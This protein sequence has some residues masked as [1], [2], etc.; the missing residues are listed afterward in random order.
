[1]KRIACILLV[2]L[3]IVPLNIAAE[4]KVGDGTW[5]AYVSGT[6]TIVNGQVTS[7]SLDPNSPITITG[8]GGV[9]PPG[10]VVP[11][12]VPGATL[13]DVVKAATAAIPEYPDKANDRRAM[14]FGMNFL[15]AIIANVPVETARKN[16]KEFSDQAVG[17]ADSPKWAT[18]WATVDAKLNTMGL[19]P[20]TYSVAIG[21]ITTALTADLPPTGA[22]P[23]TERGDETFGLSPELIEMLMKIL[24]PFLMDL[25]KSLFQK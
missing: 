4:I 5:R 8:G 23:Q 2:A 3:Q 22:A 10:P 16:V 12:V 13:T 11:P 19:T 21:D 24:L 1:V 9:V 15:K 20:E 6:A 14:A 17:E 7:F 18:W 25:I